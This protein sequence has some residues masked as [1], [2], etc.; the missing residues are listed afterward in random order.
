[1][2]RVCTVQYLFSCLLSCSLGRWWVALRLAFTGCCAA[3]R[4]VAVVILCCVLC[5]VALRCVMLR[6]PALPCLLPGWQ[7]CTLRCNFVIIE[8]D[9]VSTQAIAVCVCEGRKRRCWGCKWELLEIKR[10]REL[11]VCVCV[12]VDERG[13]AIRSKGQAKLVLRSTMPM[14]AATRSDRQLAKHKSRRTTR[15][16]V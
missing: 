16:R 5:G 1:M 8:P 10:K 11:Q 7:R 14:Q 13:I 3:L 2:L 6:C 15:H 12:C 9:G 4:V